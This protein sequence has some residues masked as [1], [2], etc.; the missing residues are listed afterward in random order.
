MS[1]RTIVFDIETYRT[2]DASVLQRLELEA[3]SKEPNKTATK[4]VKLAWHTESARNER[5]R[6]AISKTAVDPMLAEVLCVVASLD[7]SLFRFSVES[8]VE[9]QMLSK[10][11]ERIDAVA[12]PDTIWVGHNIEGFDLPVLLNRF[13]R[14]G[15]APPRAFPSFVNGRWFGRVFDTMKRIPARTPFISMDA[16][17]EAYDVPLEDVQWEGEPMH[18]G[19][20]AACYEAGD[21]KT[22]LRYCEEDVLATGELYG[23][24]T[25][26]DSW[27]TYPSPNDLK[28][29]L[30]EI[31]A[32]EALTEAQKALS[33][34]VILK[35]AGAWP[36]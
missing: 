9:E 27:G 16:A 36:R 26:D 8:Q 29:A 10:F 25:F 32:D 1:V 20:V 34:K 24:L 35:N 23:R 4:A 21:W 17:C 22:L 18:G 19:R 15:I 3:A 7:G 5:I 33:Q 11:S 14:Y 2:T 13:R 31:D 12:T 28:T 30:E 6:E